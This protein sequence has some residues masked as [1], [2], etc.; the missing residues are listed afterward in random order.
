MVL[1]V[2]SGFEKGD[3]P[4]E[5]MPS[6]GYNAAPP[7]DVSSD[8]RHLLIGRLGHLVE[9]WDLQSLKKE[10]TISMPRPPPPHRDPG[11]LSYLAYLDAGRVI[12]GYDEWIYTV[13]SN[14][15]P[16]QLEGI[17]RFPRWWAASPVGGRMAMAPFG[18]VNIF[19]VDEGKQQWQFD[20]PPVNGSH[21]LVWSSDGK[22]LLL[23]DLCGLWLFDTDGGKVIWETPELDFRR[24]WPHFSDELSGFA[25]QTEDPIPG[26]LPRDDAQYGGIQFATITPD[27]RRC[28]AGYGSS[29]SFT[30]LPTQSKLQGL[31]R[32]Y[33]VENG[34]VLWEHPSDP[35]I[36]DIGI[37]VDG[38]MVYVQTTVDFT[39][40]IELFDISNG[41]KIERRVINDAYNRYNAKIAFAPKGRSF[42]AASN[43]TWIFG[44]DP[45]ISPT[46]LPKGEYVAAAKWLSE[47]MF[48]TYGE[49]TTTR[50]YKRVR[51]DSRHGL[52]VLWETWAMHGI[53][54]AA[55]V[56]LMIYAGRRTHSELNRL[57]PWQLWVAVVTMALFAGSGL[58]GDVIDYLTRET[59]DTGYRPREGGV[60]ILGVVATLLGWVSMYKMMRLACGWYRFM[61][62]LLA[63]GVALAIWVAGRLVFFIW[64][65][66][67]SEV[68][69][70]RIY[71]HGWMH[72]VTPMAAG[73][74]L[75]GSICLMLGYWF[76]LR[77][78]S[79]AAAFSP[80]NVER[81]SINE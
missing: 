39:D 71:H 27:G 48:M 37:T 20:L 38:T 58:A 44:F 26:M 68:E 72:L 7:F 63:I 60:L 1:E 76:L 3:D 11:A 74:T 70:L 29:G 54:M 49:E 24:P 81:S 78:K 34:E 77:S 50:I 18:S 33:D 19:D 62:I 17:S 75:V 35:D 12:F 16:K 57:L 5:G 8:G 55:A 9:E 59:Y 64:K 69:P 46:R 14:G 10:R 66:G 40:V 73:V 2:P 51:P 47:D 45:E 41:S 67:A 79:V 32:L 25:S 13:E 28:I 43:N 23:K 36:R 61:L 6:I 21:V 30:V 4:S 15:K 56:C 42:V 22:R 65:F 31:L 52:W 80:N 53:L